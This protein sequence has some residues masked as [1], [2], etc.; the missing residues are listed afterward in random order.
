MRYLLDANTYIQA[1]NQ[2][3]GMDICPAYWDWL[4]HQFKQGT[5]ASVDMIGRELKDG[6]DELAEW[7]KARPE[8]F[9]KNDDTSTQLIF[10]EVV[11]AVM[12]G[13]YNAGNRD[14]FLAKADPWIIAKAKS[15]GAVVVTHESFVSLNTKKVKV[16][17]I[18]HQFGVPCLNTFQFLRELNARFVL[19]S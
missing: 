12:A 6:N 8:H 11:Q 10:A 3:Y 4:D 16:P 1:K 18:C 14:N 19:G 9:I 2:Y 17:N 5:L 7:A 13:D 15:I